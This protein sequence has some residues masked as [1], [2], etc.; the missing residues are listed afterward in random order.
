M[1]FRATNRRGKKTAR[2][3]QGTNDATKASIGDLVE[4][5]Q[6]GQ[7]FGLDYLSRFHCQPIYAERTMPPT[8]VVT[9]VYHVRG[10]AKCDFLVTVE[11]RS[12]IMTSCIPGSGRYSIPVR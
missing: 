12:L 5:R 7:A 4:C 10:G 8:N 6:A 1:L 2:K 11:K 3:E 9:V